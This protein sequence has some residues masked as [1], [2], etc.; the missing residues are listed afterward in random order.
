MNGALQVVSMKTDHLAKEREDVNKLVTDL[1]G[2]SVL[3]SPPTAVAPPSSAQRT[4]EKTTPTKPAQ[5]VSAGRSR[6]VKLV[7]D[8]MASV[9]IRPKVSVA[10]FSFKEL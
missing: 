6:Q 3:S 4:P 1:I 2:G 8:Q 7:V 9:N 5:Q 10:Y